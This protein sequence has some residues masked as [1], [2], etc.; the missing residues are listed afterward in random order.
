MKPVRTED[1]VNA[2]LDGCNVAIDAG[3]SDF[4]EMSY[5]AGVAA[6]LSWVTDEDESHPLE[7]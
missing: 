2:L 4:P 1:E 6:A 7:R 3:T 5:E